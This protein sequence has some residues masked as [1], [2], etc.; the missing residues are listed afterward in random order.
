[1][2]PRNMYVVRLSN[3]SHRALLKV[4][5]PDWPLLLSRSPLELTDGAGREHVWSA[6][7]KLLHS[8]PGP[9]SNWHALQH[10]LSSLHVIQRGIERFVALQEPANGPCPAG[11]SAV[12]H[13]VRRISILLTRH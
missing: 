7:A 8:P 3:G 4:N 12:S 1:M 5:Q 6:S 9:L 11:S 13:G 2:A 10:P